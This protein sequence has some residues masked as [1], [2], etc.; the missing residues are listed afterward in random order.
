M[1]MLQLIVLLF[2]LILATGIM[3]ID[4]ISK[5]MVQA[6]VSYQADSFFLN[7]C[8]SFAIV[9][10]EAT[11]LQ[12]IATS[13]FDYGCNFL[14]TKMNVRLQQII[15]LELPI[16]STSKLELSVEDIVVIHQDVKTDLES[17][18]I[19]L[20][21]SQTEQS[22][23]QIMVDNGDRNYA[24]GGLLQLLLR[25]VKFCAKN[26]TVRVVD[27]TNLFNYFAEVRFTELRLGKHHSVR[28]NVT[29]TDEYK[30]LYLQ[31]LSA[32][33]GEQSDVKAS[34][35]FTYMLLHIANVA[36]NRN[37]P[38]GSDEL[39]MLLGSQH[40]VFDMVVHL[41]SLHRETTE[42]NGRV[43]REKELFSAQ[44]VEM[45]LTSFE[46]TAK[47]H[48]IFGLPIH[49]EYTPKIAHLIKWVFRTRAYYQRSGTNDR[50]ASRPIATN[51]GTFPAELKMEVKDTRS[52]VSCGLRNE[53][54]SRLLVTWKTHKMTKRNGKT[55]MCIEHLALMHNVYA[56]KKDLIVE[57]IVMKYDDADDKHLLFFIHKP[58]A[59]FNWD[60]YEHLTQM[61]KE[62]DKLMVELSSLMPPSQ[63]GERMTY[64]V[65]CYNVK[66]L[67]P[68]AK[69][70]L[71]LEITVEKVVITI[72]DKLSYSLHGVTISQNCR[73]IAKYILLCI[74]KGVKG[75]WTI[76][77]DGD[78]P[79]A[80]T[81][82]LLYNM[83]FKQYAPMYE[84]L[85]RFNSVSINTNQYR[86]THLHTYINN[87][88]MHTEHTWKN[89]DT[90]ANENVLSNISSAIGQVFSFG[91][92]NQSESLST[93]TNQYRAAQSVNTDTQGNENIV[94]KIF[95]AIGQLFTV[96]RKNELLYTS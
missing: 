59:T 31:G 72:T 73:I 70:S 10:L 57:Q 65:T 35:H 28:G 55:V 16:L 86:A 24:N 89:T 2:V 88:C 30:L 19:S 49:L 20:E 42:L 63:P 40:W 94:S 41:P 25:H 46:N 56:G 93:N 7:L 83:V 37:E 43:E 90:H 62:I 61:K 3:L 68:V 4:I 47:L 54:N 6:I 91:W 96:E 71:K 53:R 77:I 29:Y 60:V 85:N 11:L 26:G 45:K 44:R 17:L 23:L 13:L 52:S 34:L 12:W 36:G 75:L 18:T 66:V 67:I 22:K 87:T 69:S 51:A 48:I 32:K 58:T 74:E 76:I 50:A 38:Y 21:I 92:L 84:W 14:W 1:P 15:I 39:N 79:F 78:G 80:V 27:R 33:I 82:M 8:I 95:G 81:P 5:W 64:I 9:A